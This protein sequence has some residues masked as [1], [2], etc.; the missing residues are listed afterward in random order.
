MLFRSAPAN[1][2]G[3]RGV[4]INTTSQAY[5]LGQI[6]QAA[7]SASKGGVEALTIPVARELARLGIRINTIS[8]GLIDTNMIRIDDLGDQSKAPIR[9]LPPGMPDISDVASKHYVFP[10]R[11]GYPSEYASLAVELISNTLLNGGSYQL[12]GAMRFGPKF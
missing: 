11:Q 12:Y 7:Y 5:M 6:G 8:P 1:E 10:Q 3:E 9:E 2:D 4:I